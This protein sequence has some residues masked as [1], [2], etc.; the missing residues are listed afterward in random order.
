MEP[1]QRQTFPEFNRIASDQLSNGTGGTISP[2]NNAND[3]LSKLGALGNIA[4][5]VLVAVAVVFIVWNVVVYMIK[6]NAE[7]SERRAA[8]ANVGWGILGL[9]IIVSI[10]SLVGILTNTF[11]TNNNRP[12]IPNADFVNNRT[13][14]NSGSYNNVDPAGELNI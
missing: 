11:R 7:P 9:A 10:W 8:L 2:L 5:Y 12:D 4:T 13:N 14:T 6:G 1:I 3:V